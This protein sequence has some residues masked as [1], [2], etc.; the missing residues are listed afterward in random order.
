MEPFSRYLW[1]WL[2]NDQRTETVVKFIDMLMH[3][4]P[5][6]QVLKSDNG[7]A[8]RSNEVRLV[9]QGYNIAQS[10]TF[11]YNPR[12][13]GAVERSHGSLKE[14][15]T[16]ECRI[17]KAKK[18]ITLSFEDLGAILSK[19]VTVLNQT[20]SCVTSKKPVDLF[21]KPITEE[22]KKQIYNR[23]IF[24][25]RS[26]NCDPESVYI[27]TVDQLEWF[28]KNFYIRCPSPD[29]L[30]ELGN[31]RVLSE[32]E[33]TYLDSRHVIRGAKVQRLNPY[34]LER[35][36]RNKKP[37]MAIECYIVASNSEYY[38][39]DLAG[40]KLFTFKEDNLIILKRSFPL[41]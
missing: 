9:C 26:K 13:N 7:S 19:C 32:P 20:K 27:G 39:L 22:T 3:Q 31:L 41:N 37:S 12:S 34:Q 30:A 38:V 6:L 21:N 23:H 14:L 4:F 16:R 1:S 33:S 2:V 40:E 28:K 17:E 5:T 10:F 25:N 35:H 11:P 15:L 8:F 36:K 29:S 18:G 24:K